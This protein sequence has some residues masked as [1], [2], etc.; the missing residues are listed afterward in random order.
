MA[1]SH[2]VIT[3][4]DI[5]CMTTSEDKKAEM[6]PISA[7]V[8]PPSLKEIMDLDNCLKE[9]DNRFEHL[10]LMIE[11]VDK[12]IDK[13]IEIMH[14]NVGSAMDRADKAVED[15]GDLYD[16]VDE[17]IEVI[18]TKSFD[19]SVN[20]K[21]EIPKIELPQIAGIKLEIPSNLMAVLWAI[22]ALSAV[23]IGIHF[24]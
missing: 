1:G 10:K 8:N 7:P 16:K 18:K 24:K 6:E 23:L 3:P 5:W 4:P 12:F 11:D 19:I 20:P 9:Y 2:T 21:I 17:L 15:F 22:A 14:E 13:E